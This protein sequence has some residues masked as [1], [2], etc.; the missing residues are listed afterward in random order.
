MTDIVT[1]LEGGVLRLGFNRPARKNAVTAQMYRDLASGISEAHTRADVRVVVLHGSEDV[2]TSGND[3]KDFA[4][5]NDEPGENPSNGF[6]QAVLALEKPLIAAVN[7]PAV[8]IGAT[9]LLHCDLVYAGEQAS[10][11]FSFVKLGLCP[12]FGSSML[13]PSIVGWQRAAELFLL[14]I[15]C[16]ARRAESFGLINQ[17]LPPKEVLPHALA[18][19]KT[20]AALAPAALR[21][22]KSL[23]REGQTDVVKNR[24]NREFA[25]FGER[26]R[27]PEAIE[28]FA[29]FFEKRAPDFSQFS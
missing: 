22:T 17:V 28:A 2:F 9:M 15:P 16:S 27:T 7:G 10:L 20:L 29:A 4:N 6:M 26:L 8:G 25:A 3:I 18:V 11:Q 21:A 13:L 1:A 23:M 5:R 19:A 24:I 14:G 12:E